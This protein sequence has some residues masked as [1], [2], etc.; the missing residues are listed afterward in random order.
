VIE[1]NYIRYHSITNY[2]QYCTSLLVYSYLINSHHA[3]LCHATLYIHILY[4]YCV[5]H[6]F[7]RILRTIHYTALHITPRL[8]YKLNHTTCHTTPHYTTAQNHHLTAPEERK[9]DSRVCIWHSFDIRMCDACSLYS[10]SIC[11]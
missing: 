6:S 9:E 7:D 10:Y 5:F 11:K 8:N 1:S 2:A 3:M 4:V